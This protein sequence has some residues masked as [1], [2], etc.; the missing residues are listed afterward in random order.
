MRSDVHEAVAVW[1]A[2]PEEAAFDL[3]LG[4]HGGA[5]SHLDPVALALADPAEH[6]HDQLMRFVGR[7]DRSADL[8]HPQGHPVVVEELEGIA[9]LVAVEGALR[10][11]DH[12]GVEPPIGVAQLVEQDRGLRPALRRDRSRLVDVEEL[13]DDHA[14]AWFDQCL[15]PGQLPVP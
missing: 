12:D 8:R 14:A 10:L 15:R 2:A 9:E 4:F 3:G 7:V 1:R 5:D 13:R 11:T 6:Q